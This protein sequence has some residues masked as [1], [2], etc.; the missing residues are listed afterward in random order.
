M[1]EF[2]A[3]LEREGVG[4]VMVGGIAVCYYGY[5]RTTQDIDVLVIP[6]PENA[7]KMEAV[8]RAFGFGEAAIPKE[9]FLKEKGAVHLGTEPNRIDILTS[10]KGIS[11]AAI[12]ENSRIITYRGISMRMIALE[13]LLTCKKSSRRAKDRAD[14]EELKKKIAS[15]NHGP[16]SASG[17]IKI[18]SI[19]R[20]PKL[21]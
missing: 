21:P 6:S 12:L 3:F 18:K 19:K 1:K 5:V 7:D 9:I 8:L 11:N 4:Y 20:N 10:L 17:S 13:D 16:S 15:G 2:I 14:F